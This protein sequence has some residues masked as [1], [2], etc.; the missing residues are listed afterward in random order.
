MNIW[1]VNHYAIPPSMGGLVRHYYFSKYLQRKGHKVKI[2]T[3]S[4][5]HN[6]DIN[7]IQG[8]I[9]YREVMEEGVE[10]TFVRSRDY[11]G[12]G[13]DRI[14]NMIELPF[15]MWKTMTSFYKKEIPDVIY[16][17]SPDLFVAFS[18][19]YFGKKHKIPVVVE[20]R[21]LWPES[22]VAYNNV[23]KNN[24]II[25]IL[26]CLERWIYEN[27]K[28]LIFT[29]PGGKDYIIEKG[30]ERKIALNKVFHINNG[31]DLE[32]FEF[33]K[34]NYIIKDEDLES[35][36][37]KVV[38]VGSIRLA[39][40]L[41]ELIDA[42]EIV[43]KRGED[44]IIFLIYGEGT[45]K[46]KLQRI[47]ELKDLNVKFKGKVEKKYVP[48]ILSKSNL[49]VVNVK[50]TKL[51]KY[52]CSWNKLFEYI[53]SERPILCNFPQK[54]DLIIENGLGVSETFKTPEEYGE[55]IIELARMSEDK[56]NK[57]LKNVKKIK[58]QYDYKGLTEI[59]EEILKQA[60]K[61]TKKI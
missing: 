39:N 30:W 55:R 8:K 23:S 52:G 54:Y 51:S 13:L 40:H 20:V 5:I 22:I 18:A 12:N 25:Q 35:D 16:T 3:S 45:E 58:M 10:Y 9:L 4:K 41:K 48:Y 19:L 42:A 31:V 2:F 29:I 38:Y 1:I 59:L 14:W 61:S 36:C 21:D 26:Y 27:A 46:E 44:D 49:N 15:K 34:E 28:Y 53:A 60:I 7:M 37:F 24:P 17:S 32:E 43:K 33:N 6:T 56:Y 50:N 11:E 47:C 57:I